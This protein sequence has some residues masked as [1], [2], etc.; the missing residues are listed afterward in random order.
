MSEYGYNPELAP[1]VTIETGKAGP[2]P[3]TVITNAQA[4]RRDARVA[5]TNGKWSSSLSD[6][7]SYIVS[8]FRSAGFS[9]STINRVLEQRYSML[10]KLGVS[11]ERI[12]F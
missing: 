8:D 12:K 4:A 3:H 10:K 9:D 7:L 1:T 6:E 11:Y 2:Y 5:T